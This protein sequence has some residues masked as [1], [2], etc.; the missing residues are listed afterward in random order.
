MTSSLKNPKWEAYLL[1]TS[2]IGA[3]AGTSDA[4]VTV[5]QY[6]PSSSTGA[7]LFSFGLLTGATNDD[8]YV[9]ALGTGA[10]GSQLSRSTST[11]YIPDSPQTSV[12]YFKNSTDP[13]GGYFKS[14]VAGDD[15]F[16]YYDEDG[17]ATFESVVQFHLDGLGGGY[18]IG[19]ASDPD[20][21]LSIQ[22]G[23]LSIPEASSAALLAMGA[24]GLVAH[25]KRRKA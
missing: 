24:V 18:V 8:L 11:A 22:Q 25:R 15:N 1:G 21:Q 3:L 16:A 13:A 23:A 14:G 17:D 2:M 12:R 20:A 4:A 7:S 6:G 10:F 19:K 5:T 9:T